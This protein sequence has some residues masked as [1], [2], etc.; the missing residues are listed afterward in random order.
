MKADLLLSCK[1]GKVI[2]MKDG[3][4]VHA[5]KTQEEGNI[6]IVACCDAECIFL[7]PY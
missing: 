3:K 1:P 4:D 2:A 7:P 6:S 5:I